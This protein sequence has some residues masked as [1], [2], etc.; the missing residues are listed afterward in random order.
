LTPRCSSF[1]GA[2]IQ[3]VVEE[4]ISQREGV[5]LPVGASLAVALGHHTIRYLVVAPTM[6][7]PEEVPALNCYRPMRVVLRIAGD[8][9]ELDRDIYCPPCR[10]EPVACFAGRR[11]MFRA[12]DS[13]RRRLT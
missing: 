8:D 2:R 12:F 11:E 1:F 6:Q 5:C 3:T 4:A 13:W 7:T 9:E 10:P